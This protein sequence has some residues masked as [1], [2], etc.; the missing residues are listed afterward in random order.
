MEN[1]F[2]FNLYELKFNLNDSLG[3]KIEKITSYMEEN[4]KNQ[5]KL[6]D[7][8]LNNNKINNENKDIID[9]DYNLQKEFDFE[10]KGILDI[11]KYL[12]ALMLNQSIIFISK[13]NFEKEFEINEKCLNKLKIIRKI[14]EENILASTY[15]N[16]I[17]IKIIKN[18]DYNIIQQYNFDLLYSIDFN[19]N[20][21]LL[22]MEKEVKEV[23]PRS[24]NKNKCL[25]F[26]NFSLFPDYHQKKISVSL[27]SKIYDKCLFINDNSFL[28][29]KNKNIELFKII[30]NNFSYINE[31]NIDIDSSDFEIIDLNSLYY[32]L[33]DH[34]KILLLN[35][36]NLVV[37]K[38][39][40]YSKNLGF[41]KISDKII[42]ILLLKENVSYQNYDILFD[43]NKWDLKKEKTILNEKFT[44]W[45]HSNNFIIFSSDNYPRKSALLEI[46][47][48]TSDDKTENIT[49][50]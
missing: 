36:N 33:N 3:K 9:A 19:S 23:K 41:L 10:V 27:K 20:F 16:I 18:C 40:I 29:L 21:D 44:N 1:Q 13:K 6:N 38:T 12:L 8:D 49:K 5:F 37:A 22:Y 39:I 17:I 7:N 28:C 45:S 42:S 46:K 32:C 14:D 43:G 11:N 31:V 26:L 48:K 30:D 50:N 34:R 15:C 25:F 4:L 24:Y 35:K 47:A 2:N